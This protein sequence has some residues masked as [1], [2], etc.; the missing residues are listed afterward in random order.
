V[1]APAPKRA[2]QV[3]GCQGPNSLPGHSG[4]EPSPQAP[5]S[6]TMSPHRARFPRPAT[7][8]V[9]V[10]QGLPASGM[11]GRTSNMSES[12]SGRTHLGT[13]TPRTV[14]YPEMVSATNPSPVAVRIPQ[15]S[16]P[17]PQS[18][19]GAARSVPPL[20]KGGPQPPHALTVRVP[21]QKPPLGLAL[22]WKRP[23][24]KRTTDPRSSPSRSAHPSGVP[25]S[26]RAAV[27]GGCHPVMNLKYS[28][29]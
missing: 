12:S 16:L 26:N 4:Y 25:L 13:S 24:G 1:P 29:H 10:L 18:L 19:I 14:V 11:P 17:P 27:C 22:R 28:L 2:G 7:A 6:A 3:H 15:A 20:G 5:H 21:G 23:L 9:Q 8:T